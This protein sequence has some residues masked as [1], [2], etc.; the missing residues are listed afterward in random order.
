MN[1]PTFRPLLWTIAI[2]P[3]AVTPVRASSI[4]TYGVIITTLGNDLQIQP[5]DQAQ[6]QAAVGDAPF[7]STGGSTTSASTGGGSATEPGLLV[8][9]NGSGGFT[10]MP[11]G[12]FS[13]GTPSGS[14]LSGTGTTGGGSSSGGGGG[15]PSFGGNITT[16]TTLVPAPPSVAAIV[17]A[18]G[19]GSSSNTSGLVAVP[20]P[21]P[22]ISGLGANTPEPATLTL[23]SIA[24]LGGL[25]F[26]R[27]RRA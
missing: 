8:T 15:S 23:L 17:P 7:A 4:T 11:Y 27:R 9:P 16:G 10:V 14:S 12:G 1:L 5:V 20:G 13:S 2:L 3:L 24:G 19:D 18:A 22:L 25:G 6:A 21:P 26:A